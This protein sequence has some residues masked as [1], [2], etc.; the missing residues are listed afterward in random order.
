SLG[1]SVTCGGD[2]LDPVV[3]GQG[4]ELVA[5]DRAIGAVAVVDPSVRGVTQDL[6]TT[7][8]IVVTPLQRRLE[9]FLCPLDGVVQ[10]V[11]GRGC[12]GWV[13]AA[14][15]AASG[16]DS[17]PWRTT[18]APADVVVESG[19]PVLRVFAVED[20]TLRSPADVVLADRGGG[21]EERVAVVVGHGG[22]VAVRVGV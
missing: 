19:F 11:F 3:V 22:A 10:P 7:V 15:H 18:R 16:G 14:A 12:A 17:E 9:L 2:L 8:R 1:L 4:D 5:A 20:G 6:M 21:H 13:G